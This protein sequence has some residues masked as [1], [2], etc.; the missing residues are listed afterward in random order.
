MK[1]V[2]TDS[3]KV[4]SSANQTV[5]MWN[6]YSDKKFEISISDYVDKNGKF[7]KKKYSEWSLYWLKNCMKNKFYNRYCIIGEDF[8]YL[9]ACLISIIKSLGSSRPI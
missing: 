4:L 9:K 8:K 1:V 2:I 5:I 7:L 6:G 3:D